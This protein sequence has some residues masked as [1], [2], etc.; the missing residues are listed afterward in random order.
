MS[1]EL[2]DDGRPIL[3]ETPRDRIG[4][5][6]WARLFVSSALRDESS[7]TAEQGRVLARSG[8]VHTLAVTTGELSARVDDADREYSVTFGA[9]PVPPRIWAAVTR[10]VRGRRPLEAAVAGRTQ[11]V[12]LEHEM[13][14]DWEEPLVPNA[15]SLRLTC[16]CG[17]TACAHIAALAYVVADTI[18][19]DP[20]LLL[21]FRGCVAAPPAA[22]AAP[23][24]TAAT[25]PVAARNGVDPW[26]VGTL[27][28]LRPLRP[29]PI[30]AV[31]KCLGPSGLTVGGHELEDVLERAYAAFA[32]TP[33]R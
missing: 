12:Q 10:G 24:E 3:V 6:P 18:D 13:T 25:A 28:E 20:S 11:A 2:V 22:P 7:V 15:R 14:L 31:L 27:P 8:S 29:L 19:R 32:A 17:H 5:G 1:P 23:E 21:R 30:G 9:A 4:H 33:G 26:Q 16:T